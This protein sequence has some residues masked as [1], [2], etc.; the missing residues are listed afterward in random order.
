MLP[1]IIR[2]IGVLLLGTCY[3]YG[4]PDRCND[5]LWTH[6]AFNVVVKTSSRSADQ[7]VY[8]WLKTATW[9][10][11][12]EKQDAGLRV[13]LPI[14][15]LPIPVNADGTYSKEQFQQFISARDE[16]RLRF[17]K[18]NEF[19]QTIERSS[20]KTIAQAW[21][22]CMERNLN[23]FGLQCWSD[24]DER[25]NGIVTLHARYNPDE[26]NP[27]LPRVRRSG[28]FIDNG[29]VIDKSNNLAD[30]NPIPISGTLVNIRRS[31][32]NAVIIRLSTTRGPC[33]Q[34]PSVDA[35][36]MNK[37]DLPPALHVKIF[38]KVSDPPGEGHPHVTVTVDKAY[39]VIGGGALANWRS[40]GSMLI[41]SRPEG[42]N[43]WYVQSKDHAWDGKGGGETTRITGWA[44]GLYDPND[45][46]DVSIKQNQ[47]NVPT[48]V[49]GNAT[50][51]LDTGYVLT[52]GGA[53]AWA[54]GPG[55]LLT[56]TYPSSE[57]SW[58]ASAKDHGAADNG[59]VTA[60]VIGI[61][62]RNGPRP[63]GKIFGPP[64]S[65]KA[66]HPSNSQTVDKEWFLTGGGART[67]CFLGNLLTGSYP[68]DTTTW[69][70]EAKDHAVPCPSEIWVYAIGLQP[71]LGSTLEL[72]TT[73]FENPQYFGRMQLAALAIAPRTVVGTDKRSVAYV[74]RRNDTLR[75]I[76]L[77]FYGNFDWRRIYDA[78]VNIIK[79]PSRLEAGT[80][81]IIP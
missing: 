52:G 70:G 24:E 77:R 43:A 34:D 41:A 6:G 42:T 79:D 15:G 39:K 20:S 18:E 71:G 4:A 55:I 78:N 13:S 65:A 16:G 37:P 25:E 46:W 8:E 12:K 5:I 49:L 56:A 33:P 63:R 21:L 9:Q 54:P 53:W 23:A 40:N 60:Y 73:D 11:F 69:R 47:A 2:S 35:L 81:L 75:K 76:A 3:V 74:S 28:L 64:Q 48:T 29:K 44:I 32:R 26:P 22:S 62:P 72:D 58:T 57:N 50:A 36:P 31:G 51:T 38:S 1:Y 80:R 14:K 67:D 59:T 19:S 68:I 7:Q 10:E 61:K 27:R 45:Q 17:F 30:G 66:P